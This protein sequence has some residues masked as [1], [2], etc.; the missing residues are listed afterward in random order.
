MSCTNSLHV[1]SRAARHTSE[2][3]SFLLRMAPV[4]PC[5]HIHLKISQYLGKKWL[6]VTATPRPGTGICFRRDISTESNA[7]L[8]K[9]AW[10]MTYYLEEALCQ[11]IVPC[12]VDALLTGCDKKNNREELDFSV[13]PGFVVKASNCTAHWK[14]IANVRGQCTGSHAKMQKQHL[15]GGFLSYLFSFF[16]SSSKRRTTEPYSGT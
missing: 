5:R 10:S 9:D 2:E 1:W 12:H 7:L 11:H 8:Q 3:R 6:Q 15:R 13:S 16:V 4:S 14:E